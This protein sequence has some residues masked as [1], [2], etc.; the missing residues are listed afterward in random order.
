MKQHY[1]TPMCALLLGEY[2]CNDMRDV[3]EFMLEKS[4]KNSLVINLV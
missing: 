2:G 3:T 1:I 4:D